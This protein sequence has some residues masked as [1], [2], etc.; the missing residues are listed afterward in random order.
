M[1]LSQVYKL[2]VQYR[3]Q[4][5]LCSVGI[6]YE[7]SAGSDPDNDS[8]DLLSEFGT[9]V[10]PLFTACWAADVSFEGLYSSCVVPNTALPGRLDGQSTPGSR[11]GD[12]C[13]ANLCSVVTLQTT[14]QTAKRQGR[15]Y[16]SGISKTDLTDGLWTSGL[17]TGPFASLAVGLV[18]ELTPGAKTFRPVFL[19]RVINGNPVTPVIMPISSARVQQIPFTQRRRT[20]KQF[21]SAG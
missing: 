6:H 21:G 3:V 17:I 15:I 19:Q 18:T 11:S 9:A 20:T 5:Q 4:D 7:C 14:N 12:S 13:P 1:A 8:S 10:A 2:L 16:V